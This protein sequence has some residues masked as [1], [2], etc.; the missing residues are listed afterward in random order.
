MKWAIFA[1]CDAFCKV[2]MHLQ[3]PVK[4]MLRQLIFYAANRNNGYLKVSSI[5]PVN[6]IWSR[7]CERTTIEAVPLTEISS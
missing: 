1:F 6:A 7:C 4:N 5:E 3:N 2:E